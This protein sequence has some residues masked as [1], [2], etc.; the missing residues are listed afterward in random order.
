MHVVVNGEPRVVDPAMT[1]AD[2]LSHLG[3]D[4]QRVAVECNR[5]L[6]RRANFARTSLADG[7]VLEVVTLVGGG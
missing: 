2:L 4:P 3:L 5:L 6:V 7:D 1:L